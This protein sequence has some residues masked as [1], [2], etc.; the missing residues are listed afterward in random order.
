MLQE[1]VV[2]TRL[3][4]QLYRAEQVRA[5]DRY[6]IED[7]GIPGIVLMQRAGTAAFEVIS[8][9]W[10]EVR[11][12]AVL[13]GGG[14]NGGDGYVVARRALDARLQVQVFA[15]SP[16]DQLR[17]DAR[18]ACE[19]YLAAGGRIDEG[20]GVELTDF[21]V[22]VDAL[23]GTGL[24]R[25][26]T[27]GYAEAIAAINGFS[28][29]VLAIDIPSGLHAD[30]GAVMG[31]AVEA[32]ATVSFIGL[33]QGMFTGEGPACCGTVWYA[34]LAVPGAVLESQ[35]PAAQLWSEYR[36]L[37]PPRRATA[38]K[39]SFGHVL[40][41]GGDAGFTGAVRM[42]AESAA[43]VGAGLVSVAT[44]SSHAAYLN[45]N[46]PEIMC[47][48]VETT[49]ELQ[50]LLTRATVVAVGPGLGQSGWA[51]GLLQAC[52]ESGL[53]MVVDADALNLL[54][55]NPKRRENWILTPHPGEVA[56]LLDS[57]SKEIQ[58]DR[59]AA[60]HN[61]LEKY[62]GVCVLKGA[63]TLVGTHGAVPGVCSLGNPGMASGG[64][65]DVL[66]GALAGLIAQGLDLFD[67]ARMGV[68]LHSAAADAAAGEGQRG[69]LALDLMPWIRRLVNA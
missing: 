5:M 60:L 51:R 33:K 1:S 49:T 14:N 25:E 30:S 66:S 54:A 31:C 42:A 36:N 17:G 62:D 19:A 45:V 59:Y 7:L 18:Q 37:L 27:G 69:M 4:E 32:D 65:G 40:V 68:C 2:T 22:V 13:C 12:I 50:S 8:R 41:V 16:P 56:R 20:P 38:H 28:G 9:Q 46:R 39:G 58:A 23:L 29:G 44:R 34:D 10:P 67:A 57:T 52:C 3:P 63:G 53:P 15:L 55:Q 11:K 24:D 43:R 35:P 26:V 6:A 61:L 21:D 47:H 48:G 64:M